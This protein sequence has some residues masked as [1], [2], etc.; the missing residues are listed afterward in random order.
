M[1]QG[2][3]I[4]DDKTAEEH[5]SNQRHPKLNLLWNYK[6]TLI[7]ILTPIIILPLPLLIPG[8]VSTFILRNHNY[9]WGVKQ[10]TSDGYPCGSISDCRRHPKFGDVLF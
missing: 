10:F 8:L 1:V 7:V 6:S 5:E 4:W 2:V 3:E 9:G